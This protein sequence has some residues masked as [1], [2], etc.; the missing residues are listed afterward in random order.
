MMVGGGFVCLWYGRKCNVPMQQME[1]N[2]GYIDRC[3]AGR[4]WANVFWQI[5]DTNIICSI[6]IVENRHRAFVILSVGRIACNKHT[7]NEKKKNRNRCDLH[8]LIADPQCLTCTTIA[9]H[10]L[11]TA[12]RLLLLSCCWLVKLQT[13]HKNNT[14]HGDQHQ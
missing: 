2:I 8:T 7:Q 5:T 13:M 14:L 3:G 6:Y 11:P 10:F 9:T 1:K 12:F 4:V